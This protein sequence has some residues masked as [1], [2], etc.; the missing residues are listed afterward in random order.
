MKNHIVPLLVLILL[1]VTAVCVVVSVR[2]SRLRGQVASLVSDVAS[3]SAGQGVGFS[4]G[5]T[6]WP[7]LGDRDYWQIRV[8]TQTMEDPGLLARVQG[9]LDRVQR[10]L[11]SDPNGRTPLG[12]ILHSDVRTAILPEDTW[13]WNQ[14]APL[15]FK[16]PGGPIPSLLPRDGDEG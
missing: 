4:E 15:P 7:P 3:I 14:P 10:T 9:D 1:A 11:L 13:L 2:N 12:R 16:P 5:V 8:T 6:F